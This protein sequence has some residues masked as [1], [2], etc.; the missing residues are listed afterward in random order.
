M[1][2]YLERIHLQRTQ[3]SRGIFHVE[4]FFIVFKLKNNLK[5]NEMSYLLSISY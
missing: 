5:M 1:P 4:Y 3:Y 2:K